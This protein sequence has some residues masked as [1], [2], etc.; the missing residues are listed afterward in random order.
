MVNLW[1]YDRRQKE[2]ELL[3]RLSKENFAYLSDEKLETKILN[4][5]ESL[6][7]SLTL[8]ELLDAALWEIAADGDIRTLKTMRKSFGTSEILIIAESRISPMEYL[9]PDIR[10]ASLLV[11]PF[12][13]D[14]AASVLREFLASVC[15][16][17]DKEDERKIVVENRQ[18]KIALPVSQIYYVEVR[19]RKVFL[20]L[21]TREYGQYTTMENMMEILPD[22]FVRCHRS[23][24]VNTKYLERVKLSENTIYLHHGHK[25]PLSRSYK[26]ALKEYILFTAQECAQAA[27]SVRT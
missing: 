14:Q 17:M 15:G 6:Q 13:K 22:S 25:V 16:T 23:F 19:E 9:T 4:T 7:A 10:A 24:A 11:R 3:L 5:P 1:I 26:P 18:G 2:A 27:H 12:G 20:R 8:Q 21:Q